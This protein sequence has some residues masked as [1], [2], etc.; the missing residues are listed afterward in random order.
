MAFAHNIQARLNREGDT[1]GNGRR[2][3]HLL[4]DLRLR[5]APRG[6]GTKSAHI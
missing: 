1:Y 6:N 2:H 3:S 4:R 5:L